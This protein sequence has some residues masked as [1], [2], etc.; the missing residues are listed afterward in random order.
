MRFSFITLIMI[1]FLYG[2]VG[3]ESKK[4]N[5]RVD[6][7]SWKTGN[8]VLKTHQ[9]G[10]FATLIISN[11]EYNQLKQKGIFEKSLNK[12]LSNRILDKY[13]DVFSHIVILTISHKDPLPYCGIYGYVSNNDEGIGLDIFDNSKQF[14][15]NGNL[16]SIIYIPT[17]Y[18]FEYN[19]FY[20]EF[21][22]KYGNYFYPTTHQNHFGFS[23][24]GILGGFN[25]ESLK[26]ISDN[27]YEA[28][29]DYYSSFNSETGY[30]FFELYLMGLASKNEV[31]SFM[32]GKCDDN[33][34]KCPYFVDNSNPSKSTF[35]ADYINNVDI[36]E[37]IAENGVRKPPYDEKS[38]KK[39][40]GIVVV[41][42]PSDIDESTLLKVDKSI[43]FQTTPAPD[44][45]KRVNFYEA[46]KGRA[47]LKWDGLFS[48]LR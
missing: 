35:Y 11:E 22:H 44:E 45:D 26:N 5:E 17:L 1:I 8:Y 40:R 34:Q 32:I 13:N 2:C 39:Y 20:H 16:E 3:G 47:F 38:I 23:S 4:E 48:E 14:G 15:S 25:N 18:C 33:K 24:G 19:V 6:E 36:N 21:A 10:R 9:S 46:T 12:I 42:S 28:D 7:S 27:I 43:E 41:V 37:L 29:F 30:S 31:P